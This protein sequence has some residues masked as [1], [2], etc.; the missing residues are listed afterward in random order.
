MKVTYPKTPNLI[1]VRVVDREVVDGMTGRV[2]NQTETTLA[3]KL[4]DFLVRLGYESAH[5]L[6][7]T[8]QLMTN[9]KVQV[10]FLESTERVELI[11][12]ADRITSPEAMSMFDDFL[13]SMKTTEEKATKGKTMRIVIQPRKK[14]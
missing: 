2:I 5:I 3:Q 14:P 8:V 4:S 10:D 11:N 9:G 13:T 7:I 6:G 12:S 1:L